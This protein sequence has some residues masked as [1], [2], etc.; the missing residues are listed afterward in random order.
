MKEELAK[1][2]NEELLAL[3]AEYMPHYEWLKHFE[4]DDGDSD[5]YY[6][7]HIWPIDLELKERGLL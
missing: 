1:L 5:M 4:G 3:K 6:C 7:E 2:T